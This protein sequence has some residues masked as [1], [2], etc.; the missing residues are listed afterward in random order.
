MS[1]TRRVP[2]IVAQTLEDS[3]WAAALESWSRVDPRMPDRYQ[4]ALIDM[5]GE[6]DTGGITPVIK[7]PIISSALGLTY[8]GSAYAPSALVPYLTE[9]LPT[10]HVFCA[11][12]IGDYTHAVI[13]YRLS[14]RGNISYM[15][16]NGGYDRWQPVTWF[17]AHGPYVLMR[18]P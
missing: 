17:Q 13:I 9:H 5:W 18:R 4:A 2:P 8:G 15:D 12:T 1:V 14:D 10:S 6:G 11:Y 7:I 16:P 3:C